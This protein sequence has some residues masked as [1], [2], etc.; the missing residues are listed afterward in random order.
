M[1]SNKLNLLSR[2][3]AYLSNK[4]IAP[5]LKKIKKVREHTQE[6]CEFKRKHNDRADMLTQ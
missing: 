5:T 3:L 2:L 1:N 6:L 4:Y